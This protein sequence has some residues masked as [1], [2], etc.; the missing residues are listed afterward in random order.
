MR[1]NN[2]APPTRTNSVIASNPL[3][4]DG[5]RKPTAERPTASRPKHPD[6][7]RS[8]EVSMDAPSAKTP[9]SR[10]TVVIHAERVGDFGDSAGSRGSG[11]I[12][13][14]EGVGR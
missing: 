13:G 1:S 11:A 6:A 5:P 7:I 3:R 10:R 14:G 8:L 12:G 2:A 4:L 9:A